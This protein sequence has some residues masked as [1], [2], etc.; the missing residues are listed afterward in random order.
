VTG[1][2]LESRVCYRTVPYPYCRRSSLAWL[3]RSLVAVPSAV[4]SNFKKSKKIKIKK[5]N[6]MEWKQKE[7]PK[8]SVVSHHATKMKKKKDNR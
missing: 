5:G 7:D 8:G 2:E 1:L 3:A 6:G 4:S